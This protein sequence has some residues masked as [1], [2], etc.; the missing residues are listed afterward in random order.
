MIAR[1]EALPLHALG[2]LSQAEVNKYSWR[3]DPGVGSLLSASLTLLLNG[4]S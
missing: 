1:K 2:S 3:P 4:V